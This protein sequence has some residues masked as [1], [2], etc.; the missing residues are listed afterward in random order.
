MYYS[1][2]RSAAQSYGTLDATSRVAAASPH[3]LVKILFE[4]LL[5]RLD[6]AKRSLDRGDVAGMLQ[7]RARA[8]DILNALEESLDFNRGGEIATALAI[9]YRE[10]SDRIDAARGDQAGEMLVSA[11]EMIAEIAEAWSEIG[12]ISQA[13]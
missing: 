12:K 8:S 2:G 6:R 11:R 5:L 1:P 10:A 4:Q 13:A 3:E 7:S 9:V